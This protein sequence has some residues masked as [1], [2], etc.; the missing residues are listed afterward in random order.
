MDCFVSSGPERAISAKLVDHKHNKGTQPLVEVTG[1]QE[2]EA[3]LAL[4]SVCC[5]QQ[6]LK[7]IRRKEEVTQCRRLEESVKSIHSP[8]LRMRDG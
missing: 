5:L 4:P 1:S 2:T 6:I 7:Y 3:L 8:G